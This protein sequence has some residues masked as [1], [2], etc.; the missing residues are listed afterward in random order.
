MKNNLKNNLSVMILCGGK[1]VRLRPIT[2]NL[3][4]PLIKIKKKEI[5]SHIIDQIQ[6]Y[7]MKDILV[8]SGYKHSLIKNFFLK[9]HIDCNIK[10][11]NSGVNNDIIKRVQ[12][13]IKYS[14]NDL[15]ICY[16][17]TLADINI[18]Q[19]YKFHVK[20]KYPA[21]I[22]SYE[23]KSNFGILQIDKKNNVKNYKEKPSLNVW[24][25][26]GYII[27]NKSIYK[28]VFRFKKF[29]DLLHSLVKKSKVKSYKHK[30]LHIT[31]NTVKELEEAKNL[32]GQFDKRVKK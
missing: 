3:P 14:K 13:V 31:I 27:I 21:T 8:T 9:N 1:G 26:I 22:C 17:D 12:S 19:L 7:G 25:N 11:I 20:N 32:V 5:L 30:G 18:G 16:G 6:S 23:M 10:I 2:K 4:K 15:L 24:F 29:E 28:N